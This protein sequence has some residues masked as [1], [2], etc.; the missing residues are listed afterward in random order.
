MHELNKCINIGP[1]ELIEVLRIFVGINE[2]PGEL[3]SA[4]SLSGVF[5]CFKF[6]FLNVKVETFN[7]FSVFSNLK[8]LYK[9]LSE[10]VSNFSNVSST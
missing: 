3:F 8:L 7:F 5:N 4:I 6:I 9:Y 10:S 2:T 1:I